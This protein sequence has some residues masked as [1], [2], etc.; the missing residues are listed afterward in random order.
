MGH[1]TCVQANRAPAE[2]AVEHL[3]RPTLQP[4]PYEDL[5]GPRCTLA[6]HQAAIQIKLVLGRLPPQGKGTLRAILREWVTRLEMEVLQDLTRS[7]HSNGLQ[8]ER[9]HAR[10]QPA[11]RQC[12]T[13][14]SRGATLVKL[15]GACP[16]VAWAMLGTILS[17]PCVCVSCPLA[18]HGWG[19][20]MHSASGTSPP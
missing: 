20:E 9:M 1:V 6:L 7:I 13:Y 8:E 18:G 2:A 14:A 3:V 15:D 19:C 11:D 10:S 12:A 16:G 4:T 5:P 17:S